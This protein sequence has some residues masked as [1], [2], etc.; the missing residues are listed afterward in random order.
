MKKTLFLAAAGLLFASTAWALTVDTNL[1]GYNVNTNLNTS[2]SGLNVNTNVGGLNSNVNILNDGSGKTLNVN[3]STGLSTQVNLD[4]AAKS[5]IVNLNGNSVSLIKSDSDLAAYSDLV[6]Q[7][8]PSIKSVETGNGK[9][10]VAYRQPAK[11]LG[12]IGTNMGATVTV[13]AQGNVTV[14]LPWYSFLFTKNTNA[15]KTAVQ[16]NLGSSRLDVSVLG[17]S[18]STSVRVQTGAKVVNVVTN[19]IETQVS[20]E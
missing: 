4:D 16:G 3:M 11:F 10:V 15:V 5:V 19:S 14:S 6:V 13:N 17:G 7:E 12:L 8:R 9:V 1:G 20:A 18:G 2:G